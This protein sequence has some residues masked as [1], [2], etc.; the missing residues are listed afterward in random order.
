MS[1]YPRMV[2]IEEEEN[3]S[4]AVS[5]N[6]A[7]NS[8]NTIHSDL[9]TFPSIPSSISRNFTNVL[10]IVVESDIEPATNST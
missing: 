9:A 10:E 7:T 3:R 6:H 2:E 4:R 5:S 1:K 8:T